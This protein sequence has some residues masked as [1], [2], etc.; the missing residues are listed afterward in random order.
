M[1]SWSVRNGWKNYTS[2]YKTAT[3]RHISVCWFTH[4]SIK[5]CNIWMVR[6]RTN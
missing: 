4:Q 1:P 5:H 6:R 2:V 3:Y